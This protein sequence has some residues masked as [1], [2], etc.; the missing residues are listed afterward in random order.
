MLDYSSTSLIAHWIRDEIRVIS[1]LACI[2]AS[3]LEQEQANPLCAAVLIFLR[4]PEGAGTAASMTFH[5]VLLWARATYVGI[6]K[7]R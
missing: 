7:P 5:P 4:V 1:T 3:L 2:W 6:R